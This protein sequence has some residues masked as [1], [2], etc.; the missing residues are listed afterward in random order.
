[1]TINF[2]TLFA[3]VG[4]FLKVAQSLD[5]TA[6][7]DLVTNLRAAEEELD[8]E[9][10][11]FQQAVLGTLETTLD[12]QLV[13]IGSMITQLVG[14][15]VQNLIVETV[16]L[17]TPLVNKNLDSALAVLIEQMDDGAESV[18]ASTITTSITYGEN[19]SSSG[20][21]DNWGN[22]FIF[23]CTRRGDGQVNQ[24]IV[25]ET[26]RCEI[27][28]VS[29]SGTATWTLQ[30][31][32]SEQLT[33]PLWPGGSGTNRSL[34]SNLASSGLV[35]NGGFEDSDDYATWL[36]ENW[37]LSV[38]TLNTHIRQTTTE[39]Q[40]VTVNG[41][42][43]AG[44]YTLKFL[45]RQGDTHTTVPL[46]FNASASSV[47]SALRKLPGLGSVTVSSTGT[48][49]NLTHT[50]VFTGTTNP[51]QLQST[52]GLTGGSPTI[53]HATTVVGSPWAAR[54]ARCLQFVGDGSTLTCIQVPV[55][56]TAKTC[57]AFNLWAVVDVTPAAGVLTID[58]VDGIGDEVVA[59]DE[60]TNNTTT[61][62]LTALTTSHQASTVA[63]H[64]PSTMP[65]QVYLR[66]RLT[67]ALSNGSSL[68]VDEC[69][70]VAMQ[71][72]YTGGLWAA[73]FSGP[74]DFRVADYCE[75]TVANDYGGELH[76]W[77]HRLLSLG[78]KRV[79][80]PVASPGTQPDSLVA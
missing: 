46:T 23:L 36:P 45:D 26:I 71:E 2:D 51:S 65:A 33:N 29:S 28:S 76:T 20:T 15:P 1:M 34:T 78:N 43:L 5:N 22:G 14:G 12:Q 53:T 17:D 61:L 10:H 39:Q 9:Q 52:S 47:Q 59:D 67:T 72:L 38:G 66:L 74:E 11:D 24:F 35:P 73:G 69:C 13:A 49:A 44:Y 27:T 63:F 48:G 6:A 37:V 40:T 77:L 7:A 4:K 60:G 41:S 31:E 21:G 16:H 75:I 25:A 55:T 79:L 68:F 42:P 50:V 54:G 18:D 70:L 62:D 56:L 80:L 64:T 8:T 57:Y 58:L 3:R 19:S 30:G 32:P